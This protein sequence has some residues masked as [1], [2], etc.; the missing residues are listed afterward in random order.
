MRKRTLISMALFF[1]FLFLSS[2]SLAEVTE[3]KPVQTK[4]IK[5]HTILHLIK[6]DDNFNKEQ[7]KN[8]KDNETWYRYLVK[9]STSP[10]D[11]LNYQET[12][13]NPRKIDDAKKLHDARFDIVHKIKII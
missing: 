8:V 10:R 9:E 4:T 1:G 7:Y 11:V 3:E 6:L 5:D 13:E 12:F 2:V